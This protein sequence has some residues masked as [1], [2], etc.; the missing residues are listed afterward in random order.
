MI[1]ALLGAKKVYSV[2]VDEESVAILR[3]NIERL[4]G[5]EPLLENIEPVASEVQDFLPAVPPH[6]IYSNEVL[7]HMDDRQSFYD[8]VGTPGFL[9][10][11]GACGARQNP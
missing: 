10:A 5:R 8:L 1:F 11:G 2:E 6:L 3:S 9:R 4:S 7:S